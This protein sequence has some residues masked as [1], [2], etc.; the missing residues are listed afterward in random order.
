MKKIF[1]DASIQTKLICTH[2]LLILIPTILIIW[3]FYTSLYDLIVNDSV[4]QAFALSR[5]SA[6]ALEA[7][8]G[9][10]SA[11]SSA[12]RSNTF[13]RQLCT[14]SVPEE[15][16]EQLVRN[17]AFLNDLS[18]ELEADIEGTMI[19]SIHIYTDHGISFFRSP[20]RTAPTGTGS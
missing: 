10:L 7:Q 12:I 6:A 11:V 1:R 8:L 16:K 18:S 9:P 15:D 3:L 2:L 19:S 17:N 13:I 20:A 5:Q 4:R 14:D